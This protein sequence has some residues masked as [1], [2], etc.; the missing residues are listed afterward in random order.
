LDQKIRSCALGG[1]VD[2]GKKKRNGTFGCKKVLPPARDIAGGGE[3]KENKRGRSKE[4][5]QKFQGGKR[6]APRDG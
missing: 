2:P 4:K 5:N 3:K 1:G 6:A